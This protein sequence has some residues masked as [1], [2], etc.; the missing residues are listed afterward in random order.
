MFKPQFIRLKYTSEQGC[1]PGNNVSQKGGAGF[2]LISGS[3]ILAAI[4]FT[5]WHSYL[6][7]HSVVEI[8]SIL[9]SFSIFIFALNTLAFS[10]KRYLAVLGIAYLFVGGF[11]LL[12]MLSYKGMGVIA[13]DGS[14]H[15]TQT[16]IVARYIESMSL[17]ILPFLFDRKIDY[18]PVFILY[19]LVSLVFFLFIFVFP[20]F[21]DCYIEGTGLS[22]FKITS[23]YVICLILL[24]A[25]FVLYRQRQKVDDIMFKLLFASIVLTIASEIAFTSYVNVYGPA[26]LIGHMLKLVSSYFIYRAIVGRGLLQP[27]RT[28]FRELAESQ[29]ELEKYSRSLES[30]VAERTMELEESNRELRYLSGQL[31]TAEE[32]ERRRIAR[33][34][35]DS[36]GQLLSAIKLSME[37]ALAGFGF[38]LE[39]KDVAEIERI[40]SMARTAIVEVRRIIVNL[41]PPLLEKGILNTIEIFCRDFARLHP[42]IMVDHNLRAHEEAISEDV[43]VI[44]FRLLQESLN[45]I[46][47]HSGASH[48][49]VLL[50][51]EEGKLRFEVADNGHGFELN[52]AGVSQGQ[53][54]F[55]L[56]GMRERA[57]LSGASF[58]IRT[59]QDGGTLIQVVWSVET[60]NDRAVSTV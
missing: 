39:E 3:F 32:N 47:K 56:S 4:Y 2:G 11:D 17:L 1:Q 5:S 49:S 20:I 24:I 7:F 12:H 51:S 37:N 35:H 14:N 26:N 44:I 19:S 42:G 55:G 15:A 16:W 41:R 22:L 10:R 59:R 58:Q 38:R 36:I 28:M 31:I 48:V 9:V 33:D 25:A 34:L 30:R 53:T 40:V 21:P 50:S 13:V 57:E 18:R 46:A 43:K 8:F 6:L 27:Y 52:P 60:S 45:N 23:E 54:G 29:K